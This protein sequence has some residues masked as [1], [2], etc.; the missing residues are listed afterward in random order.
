MII[1][2]TDESVFEDETQI[3]MT[4]FRKL[5]ES[6]IEEQDIGMED[7]PPV[8]DNREIDEEDKQSITEDD[9]EQERELVTK[10][11]AEEEKKSIIEDVEKEKRSSTEEEATAERND[12]ATTTKPTILPR[13][14]K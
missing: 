5:E 11:T 2:Y 10:E 12:A 3:K 14:V 1:T 6:I 4:T 8:K 13:T 7:K 9:V